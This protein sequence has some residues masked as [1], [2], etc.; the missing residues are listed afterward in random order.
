MQE[1]KDKQ[2]KI[3]KRK[4]LIDG[5]EYEYILE[6]KKIKN[7]RLRIEMDCTLRVAANDNVTI[8]YIEEFLKKNQRSIDRGLEKYKD[9]IFGNELKEYISGEIIYILGTPRE[10][11]V[12]E[13][14]NENVVL[15]D[16]QLILSVRDQD[17][18]KHKE[19]K[20]GAWL[21]KYREELLLNMCKD[22]YERYQENYS[23]V[24]TSFPEIQFKTMKSRWG[25]CM[26]R[27]GKI[28]LNNSLV[29]TPLKCIE[30]VV[31]HEFAHFLVPNHSKDFYNVVKLHMADY[32]KWD[33][34]L[35][36]YKCDGVR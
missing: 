36:H 31:V 4:V 20:V 17:D 1:K 26:Y 3:E 22:V 23:D 35:N 29:H 9:V 19:R 10:L 7:L 8:D 18:V 6:R 15:T 33:K 32:K 13:E 11:V 24:I 2:S 34:E 27:K 25:A 12:I 5:K 16:S 28:V 14:W 21:R 30:Y